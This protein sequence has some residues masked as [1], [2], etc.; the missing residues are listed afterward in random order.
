MPL[1]E[2]GRHADASFEHAG[3]LLRQFDGGLGASADVGAAASAVDT[4]LKTYGPRSFP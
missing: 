1:A 3:A 2:I 4:P